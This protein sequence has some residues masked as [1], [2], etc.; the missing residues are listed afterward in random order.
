MASQNKIFFAKEQ[1]K[2]AA[3]ST[4]KVQ[5]TSLRTIFQK[6]TTFLAPT[7]FTV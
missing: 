6:N 2:E 3:K 4:V 1:G 5:N 7:C